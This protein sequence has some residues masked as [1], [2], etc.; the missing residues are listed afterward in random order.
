MPQTTL[1]RLGA[2]A[3]LMTSA[4]FLSRIIGWLREAFVAA[5]FGAT[6]VTDAFYAAFTLPDIL[7]Y[8]LAG[9]VLSITFLP[10]YSRHLAKGDEQGA[11]RVLS[12]VGTLLVTVLG[13]GIVLG[14]IFAEPLCRLLF[15]ELR[16]EAL[17]AC[18]HYTRILLPAQLF[19]FAGG[20]LSA[21]LFARGRFAAAALAPLLYNLGIIAGGV[22][23]GHRL[24]P[25]SLAWGAL[26]GAALGP[27]LIPAVSAIRAGAR[28][29]PRLAPRDPGFVEWFK[30]TLPLMLGVSLVT[31]DDWL[32]RVLAGGD[33][34]EITR[35]NLAK[36]LVA[37]PI[38]IAGQA[39][40]QASMPFFAHL[41][42]E[43]K[44][45]ELAATFLKTARIAGVVALLASAWMI[46]LA[47]PLVDLLF[48]RH[49]FTYQD[50]GPT[51]TYLAIFAAAVPLWSLQGL[52][53]RVFYAAHNTVTPMLAGTIVTIASI[54]MYVFLHR[55]L[56]PAGLAVASGVGML[57]HAGAMLYLAPRILPELREAAPVALRGLAKGL[58]LAILAGA[59]ARAL[60][61]G[62][63]TLLSAPGHGPVV[64]LCA[65]GSAGF[66]SVVLILAKPMGV[67][68]P[69][70]LVSKVSSRLRRARRAG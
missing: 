26:F 44:R 39:V 67:E 59:T 40:G 23:L 49:R 8:M 36:R 53:S 43:G 30:L 54:P 58:L 61:A 16:P 27:F 51:A 32:I 62:T 70:L 69:A 46:G 21:T 60:A 1:R 17:A 28:M 37:V 41:F 66:V 10:L 64:I 65:A 50:V 63:G 22:L 9:G 13:V 33:E 68:E 34:G 7:N 19:F 20:L 52:T 57:G 35:L 14:E 18:V 47:E 5:R 56:G 48:R 15:Q 24:G 38:A 3:L 55:S 31:A 42:A 12:V 29:F 6:G 2:A 11:N 4:V 25:A 45:E